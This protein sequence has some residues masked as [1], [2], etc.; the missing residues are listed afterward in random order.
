[1]GML[2]GRIQHTHEKTDIAVKRY[3][4]RHVSP[5]DPSVIDTTPRTWEEPKEERP[6]NHIHKVLV[7]RDPPAILVLLRMQRVEHRAS[8]QV[9]RPHHRG[10]PD[11]HAPT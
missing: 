1:M 5:D 3:P 6:N 9:L 10:G 11:E 7:S 2:L 4:A 8:D